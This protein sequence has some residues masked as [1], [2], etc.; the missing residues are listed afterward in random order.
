MLLWLRDFSL[1]YASSLC[2]ISILYFNQKRYEA[3]SVLC[4]G[5]WYRALCPGLPSFLQSSDFQ[6]L[7]SP[8]I[9]PTGLHQCLDAGAMQGCCCLPLLL[10][11]SLL[12]SEQSTHPAVP[13]QAASLLS[14]LFSSKYSLPVRCHI[15]SPSLPALKLPFPLRVQKVAECRKIPEHSHKSSLKIFFLF[16]SLF[17]PLPSF[18]TLLSPSSVSPLFFSLFYFPFFGLLKLK[19]DM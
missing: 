17:L 2:P 15:S 4:Q 9:Q 3:D 7:G 6:I 11:G 5:L 13:S 12:C 19:L 1:F 16:P 8:A 14:F 10:E 18:S